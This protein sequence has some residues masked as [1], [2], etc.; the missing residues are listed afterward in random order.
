MRSSMP[1]LEFRENLSGNGLVVS[2]RLWGRCYGPGVWL[3][4]PCF[5]FLSG[6]LEAFYDSDL[7]LSLT[8][9]SYPFIR[10]LPSPSLSL[11]SLPSSSH[12]HPCLSHSCPH[13]VSTS[14][15]IHHLSVVM[16]SFLL[17]GLQL[18]TLHSY[19]PLRAGSMSIISS[20]LQPYSC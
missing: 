3:F 18:P 4:H 14:L 9:P 13:L 8:V 7:P 12:Y 17:S 5:Q 15:Q 16:S 20:P 11:L 1:S 6:Q 10:V 19:S 2:G